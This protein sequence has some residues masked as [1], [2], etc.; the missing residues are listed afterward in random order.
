GALVQRY[1]RVEDPHTRERFAVLGCAPCGLG[2]TSPVP[3]DLSPYYGGG[4]HGGRHGLTHALCLWRR[5]RLLD[6][7]GGRGAVLDVGCG[8]G[9]FLAA[10]RGRGWQVAGTE[11]SSAATR[12]KGIEV[13]G[14]IAEA[15]GPFDCATLWHS[16][17]HLRD[18]RGALEQIRQR[19]AP[20]GSILVAVPDAQGAQARLFGTLW[21]HL[22]VPRHLF[23]FGRASLG[24]L[25]TRAGFDPDWWWH[26]EIEY[27]LLGWT[28]SAL[29]ASSWT[30]DLLL[31][32]L[33]GR[34]RSAPELVAGLLLGGV[35]GAV[36]APVAVATALA[37]SGGTLIVAAR[38]RQ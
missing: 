15:K 32:S 2:H 10:A 21:R 19:I 12:E 8:D 3:E 23:H 22:D 20:G 33:S 27:D 37:G 36:A 25:L 6:R 38:R 14:S 9:S 5:V 4:Y 28:Q 31:R 24:A 7:F 11:M 18:P 26:Q 34:H 17:E 16:L 35:L 1:S 29:N 30:H 13:H